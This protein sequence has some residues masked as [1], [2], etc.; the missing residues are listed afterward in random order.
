MTCPPLFIV[1]RHCAA[2]RAKFFKPPR[3]LATSKTFAP[4]WNRRMRSKAA[5]ESA[6]D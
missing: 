3:D 2:T 6:G 1:V 4:K 5:M